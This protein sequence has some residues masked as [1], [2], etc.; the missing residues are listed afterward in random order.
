[1]LDLVVTFQDGAIDK[2]RAA[3]IFTKDLI[4]NAKSGYLWCQDISFD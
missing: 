4:K 3:E 2:N 1:M